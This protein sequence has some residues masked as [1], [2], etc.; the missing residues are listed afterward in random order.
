MDHPD[1]SGDTLT[2][3]LGLVGWILLTFL[4]MTL[5]ANTGPPTLKNILDFHSIELE[6]FLPLSD[7][8]GQQIK[9]SALPPHRAELS[10]DI[11][12]SRRTE[13]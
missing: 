11:N 8:A 7:I 10:V 2:R 1:F 13:D 3:L 4:L 9:P 5:L 6:I 12:I